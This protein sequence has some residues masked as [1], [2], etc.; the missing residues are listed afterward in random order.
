MVENCSFALGV[1]G[2]VPDV[3]LPKELV[4]RGIELA[5]VLVPR[6]ALDAH[7][8]FVP[9][10]LSQRN[11]SRH[12]GVGLVG[13]PEPR[14]VD[15]GEDSQ[16]RLGKDTFSLVFSREGD[17]EEQRLATAETLHLPQIGLAPPFT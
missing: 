17:A 4:K 10:H 5:E 3:D 2:L 12:I 16:P 6:P 9:A 11:H 14:P 7:H 15:C 13:E 8:H 1:D